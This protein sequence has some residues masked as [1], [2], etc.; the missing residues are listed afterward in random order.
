MKKTLLILAA[1]GL[2]SFSEGDKHCYVKVTKTFYNEFNGYKKGCNV[3]NAAIDTNGDYYISINAYNEFQELFETKSSATIYWL[4]PN[5]FPQ[6]TMNES[7]V[8]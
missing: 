3:L 8:K 5:A 6:D 2:I 7:E 4:S 1:I